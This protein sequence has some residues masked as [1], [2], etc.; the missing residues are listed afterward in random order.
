MPRKDAGPKDVHVHS[1]IVNGAGYSVQCAEC[2]TRGPAFHPLLPPATTDGIEQRTLFDDSPP[3]PPPQD[4]AGHL[5]AMRLAES[6]GWSTWNG[7]VVCPACRARLN[8]R[9]RVLDVWMGVV[10]DE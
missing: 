9:K 1:Q 7:R 4:P 5:G 10:G 2:K 3:E 6:R 8:G